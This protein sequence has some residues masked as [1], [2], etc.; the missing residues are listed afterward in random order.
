M[1]YPNQF[2]PP[3]QPSGGGGSVLLWVLLIVGL[4]VL[5]VCGGLCAGC[6]VAVQRAS[7]AIEEGMEQAPLWIVYFE[8]QS[9][10]EQDPQVIDRLGEP[11]EPDTYRRSVQ[12]PLQRGGETIQYDITGP[13]GK[14]IVSAVAVAEAQDAWRVSKITVTFEDGSVVDVPPPAFDPGAFDDSDDMPG[15]IETFDDDAALRDQPDDDAIAP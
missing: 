9:A 7:K 1:S 10:V 14:A 11:I 8:T 12:G 4:I 15:P 13:R 5:L 6:Y 2:G 3:E